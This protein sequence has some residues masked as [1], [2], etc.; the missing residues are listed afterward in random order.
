LLCAAV[1]AAEAGE[2]LCVSKPRR[3]GG[4]RRSQHQAYACMQRSLACSWQLPPVN[5]FS[6]TSALLA[7]TCTFPAVRCCP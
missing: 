5:Y 1:A 7:F 4:H 6:L 2:R 3:L